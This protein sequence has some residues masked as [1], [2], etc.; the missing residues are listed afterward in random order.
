LTYT[1]TLDPEAEPD[2]DL[3]VSFEVERVAIFQ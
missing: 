1:V 3:S 2:G